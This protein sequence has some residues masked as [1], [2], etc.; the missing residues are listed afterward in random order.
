MGWKLLFFGVFT[1]AAWV[2]RRLGLSPQS[3]AKPGSTWSPARRK[4]D[5]T[6]QW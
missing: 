1:P 6:S 4:E 2:L 3:V 5:F